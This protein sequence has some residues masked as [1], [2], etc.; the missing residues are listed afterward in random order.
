[1]LVWYSPVAIH[2]GIQAEAKPGEVRATLADRDRIDV[3]DPVQIFL[4][5]FNDGRQAYV[6]GVNPFGVQLDRALAEGDASVQNAGR[7]FRRARGRARAGRPEP[8]L[9]VRIAGSPDGARLRRGGANPLVQA[10]TL[11]GLS[12]LRPRARRR[13]EPGRHD[14]GRRA[15]GWRRVERRPR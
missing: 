2:F 8:R 7:L 13:P 15:A 5:T 12:D 6:F 9:R 3:D 4:S 1:V 14:E 11:E 10:G